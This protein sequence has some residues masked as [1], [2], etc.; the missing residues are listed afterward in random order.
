MKKKEKITIN[1][2]QQIIFGVN[3]TL[4]IKVMAIKISVEEYLNKTRSY[5][6]YIVSNLKKSDTWKI[7]LTIPNNF[8]SCIDNDEKCVMMH[9][10]S[11]NMEIRMNVKQMKLKM[12]F[13]D[14]LENRYQ[15][16]L[17]SMQGSEFVFDYVH[18]LY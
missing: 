4:N 12:N 15:N 5:L 11:D 13:S 6:K 18:S 2:Q 1:Q 14:S 8:T 7:Q 3:I 10:K 17:E 9:T 16:N